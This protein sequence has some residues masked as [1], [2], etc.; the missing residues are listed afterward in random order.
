MFS[1][2][3]PPNNHPPTHKHT[4]NTH[5]QTGLEFHQ[6]NLFEVWP[7]VLKPL[8]TFMSFTT[9][10][11]WCLL[12]LCPVAQNLTKKTHLQAWHKCNI[13]W[14]SFLIC[15]LNAG[16]CVAHSIPIN[17]FKRGGIE[18]LC[19]PLCSCYRAAAIMTVTYGGNLLYLQIW[20]DH[21][22][23]SAHII[24]AGI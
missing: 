7:D 6:G 10:W 19:W 5:P 23:W 18:S 21:S 14:T 9:G 20:H 16:Y 24:I 17:E 22:V 2:L 15:I 4:H 12:L 3:Q 1:I 13:A 8:S 11:P